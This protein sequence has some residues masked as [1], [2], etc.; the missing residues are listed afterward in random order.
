MNIEK[1]RKKDKRLTRKAALWCLAGLLLLSLPVVIKTFTLAPADELPAVLDYY[2]E[3]HLPLKNRFITI[4][5]FVDYFILG[6]APG[7][8]VIKGKKDIAGQ[9]RWYFYKPTLK[10]YR[11]TESYS[12][13][14]LERAAGYL[15]ELKEACDGIGAPFILFIAPN[16]MTV[17]GD[18]YLPDHYLSQEKAAP[19]SRT[20]Q[21]VSYLRENTEIHVVFP[22]NELKKAAEE[23]TE[24]LFYH[25]DTHWNYLG[26]YY[27]AKSLLREI[28]KAEQLPDVT[29]DMLSAQSGPM[30]RWNG[31]DLVN[32]MG[33]E[34]IITEDHSW[35]IE[36]C[37]ETTVSY[38]TKDA[39]GYDAF[40][41]YARASSDARDDRKVLMIRDSFGT[42]ILPYLGA[43]FR[44]VYS[45]YSAYYRMD[46]LETERPDIVILEFVERDDALNYDPE[47]WR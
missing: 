32:M 8:D 7:N 10:D 46:M 14:D 29:P 33:L 19:L 23:R 1:K 34:G 41:T 35:K 5:S 36:N 9:D 37:P 20:E 12:E 4:N 39:S 42:A 30:F 17:Y 15:S 21:L 11:H 24:P 38:E 31:F 13:N 22:E 26:G 45:P 3:E 18:R 6:D 25:L 44:E 2:L 47:R 43:C 40:Y 28:P 27:G 16:K